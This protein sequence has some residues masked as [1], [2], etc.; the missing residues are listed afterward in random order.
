ME[1]QTIPNINT[2]HCISTKYKFRF[3]DLPKRRVIVFFSSFNLNE[4]CDTT[5]FTID[6]I[7][8]D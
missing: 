5:R 3:V 8:T 6:E 7:N 4:I 1:F 2:T